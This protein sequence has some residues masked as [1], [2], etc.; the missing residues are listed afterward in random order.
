MT[1]ATTTFIYFII[2]DLA[3]AASFMMSKAKPK[4]IHQ[5]GGF[6]RLFVDSVDF[7]ISELMYCNCWCCQSILPYVIIIYYITGGFRRKSQM[8]A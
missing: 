4:L 8:D 3:K 6:V 5:I 1:L 7:F 2:D